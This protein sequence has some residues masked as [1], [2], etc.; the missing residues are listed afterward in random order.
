MLEITYFLFSVVLVS[1]SGALMPGPVLAVVVRNAPRNRWAGI[2]AAFG[3]GLI[4]LPL[5]VAIAFGFKHVFAS[6]TA[7]AVIGFIGGAALVYM[8]IGAVRA[9][10]E[11]PAQAGETQRP[12]S[13]LQGLLASINPYFFLWWATA[14]AAIVAKAVAWSYSV[15]TLMFCAHILV[16]L[17]WYGAIGFGLGKTLGPKS[18]LI[19]PLLIFCGIAMISFGIYFF[20]TSLG[21]I[22]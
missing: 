6:E 12:R 1:L 15:L 3:H 21:F 22:R 14:G 20:G 7:Q 8:G 18:H 4:E 16:D 13:I 19:R 17:V 5:V 11:T 9:R 2:E 10:P